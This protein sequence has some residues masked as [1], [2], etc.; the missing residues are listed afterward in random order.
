MSLGVV[1]HVDIRVYEKRGLLGVVIHVKILSKTCL[2][3]W[4]FWSRWRLALWTGTQVRSKAL[5]AGS[6]R[7]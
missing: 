7:L 4:C 6:G 2:A 5:V 1:I 3:S